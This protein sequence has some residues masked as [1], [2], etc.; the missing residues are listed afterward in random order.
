MP[1]DEKLTVKIVLY[2][3]ALLLARPFE[4]LVS[5]RYRGGNARGVAVERRYVKHVEIVVVECRALNSVL[6]ECE[7]TDLCARALVN[8]LYLRIRGVFNAVYLIPAE[9]LDGYLV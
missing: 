6:S 1:G 5:L 3:I 9:K 4:I 8:R 2:N 7:R